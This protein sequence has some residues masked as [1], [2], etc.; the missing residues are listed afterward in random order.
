MATTNDIESQA[1]V[2]TANAGLSEAE[3]DNVGSNQK[4][5]T[6]GQSW[7]KLVNML[8]SRADVEIGGCTPVPHEERSEKSY[9]N[10]FTLWFSM[11]CNPLP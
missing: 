6:K 9:F 4:H 2:T 8:Q 10:M 11:S 3:K 7:K 1:H 5:G